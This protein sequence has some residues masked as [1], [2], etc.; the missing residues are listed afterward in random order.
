[1]TLE[2]KV[3]LL[4]G[5]GRGIG[6]WIAVKCAKE[7]AALLLLART[8]REL[9]DTLDLV[10]VSSPKSYFEVCDI[11]RSQEVQHAVQGAVNRFGTIDALVN[12]AAVQSPI[13]PFADNP[14]GEW[15]RTIEINLLGTATTIKEVLPVMLRQ[16]KGKIVNFSGGGATAPRTNFS[17]YG[18]S[19]TAVVRFT[20][21]LALELAKYHIDVNAVAPGAVNTGMLKEVLRAG[22]SAGREYVE[23]RQRD[24]AGGD[25]PSLAADLVAFLISDESDGITGKLISAKWDPWREKGFQDVLRKETDVATLRRIDLKSFIRKP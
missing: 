19:K 23:A 11:S 10:K 9:R 7:G 16:G 22:E 12:I 2:N 15:W 6:R 18:I 3:V 13:G 25:D 5:A 4:A 17:A 8:E 20:E 24:V 21:T 14:L 1:M